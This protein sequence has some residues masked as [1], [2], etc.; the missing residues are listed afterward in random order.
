MTRGTVIACG[1]GIV[2][3]TAAIWTEERRRR[4][5]V[6]RLLAGWETD[7]RNTWRLAVDF[8]DRVLIDGDSEAYAQL[9]RRSSKS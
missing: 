8:V 4:N 5:E 3:V 7:M 2:T 6:E 1:V 9:C